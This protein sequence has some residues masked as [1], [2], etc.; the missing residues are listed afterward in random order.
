MHP[1]KKVWKSFDKFENLN[2]FFKFSNYLTNLINLKNIFK[3]SILSKDF[4][5]FF[6]GCK[7]NYL[8]NIFF[9]TLFGP[10]L[11]R[12]EYR[13]HRKNRD[14]SRHQIHILVIL[15]HMFVYCYGSSLKLLSNKLSICLSELS[16]NKHKSQTWPGWTFT[17]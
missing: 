10:K 6:Q 9:K 2:K 13:F 17:E 4:Q 11:W 14:T 15:T 8:S 1:W 5:T 3:F 12:Q 7:S 16:R